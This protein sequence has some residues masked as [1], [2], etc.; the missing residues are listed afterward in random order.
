MSLR[1]RARAFPHFHSIGFE[2]VSAFTTPDLSDAHP[3]AL[4]L[5]FQFRQFGRRACFAGPVST[6]ACHA[7]N[8]RVAEAVTEPGNGRVLLIDGQGAL[9]RSL[10][11][12]RLAQLAAD[13]DWSGVVVIGAIRDVEVIEAIDIGVQALGVCPVKT[14]KRGVGDRDIP[15]MLREVMVSPGDWLYADSNGVLVSRASLHD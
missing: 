9:H 1:R 5:A 14:D 4:H 8:S 11:G 10:L 3:E 15:L 7:D 6:I 12:D 13:N 2:E